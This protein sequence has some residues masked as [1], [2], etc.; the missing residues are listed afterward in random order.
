MPG[1]RSPA[2]PWSQLTR[3]I[4]DALKRNVG[5]QK[6]PVRQAEVAQDAPLHD[7]FRL[8][9]E[10]WVAMS[11]MWAAILTCAPR[12]QAAYRRRAV[13]NDRPPAAATATPAAS[14]LTQALRAEAGRLGLSAVGVTS[15]DSKYTFA[16]YEGLAVGETVVVGILEQNY[17][18]TQNIPS[19]RSERAALSTYAQLEDRMTALAEWIKAQ[20][21]Q[22]RTEGYLGESMVIPYAVEAGLGPI[23]F[24]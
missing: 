10:I 14:E 21:F 22:A 6:D 5:I 8:N 23:P 12:V 11:H 20:G 7:F 2:R 9:P 1:L 18:A 3:P 15:R 19:V 16:E 17:G 13:S 4:P 24:S